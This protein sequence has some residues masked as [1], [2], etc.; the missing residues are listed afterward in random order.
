MLGNLKSIYTSRGELARL[1]VIISRMLELSPDSASD[2]RDRGLVAMRLGSSRVAASDLRRYLELLPD[3]ADSAEML[4]LVG[5][6]EAGAAS[7]N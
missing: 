7:L 4:R 1:L 5:K 6:L 3:A 2:L